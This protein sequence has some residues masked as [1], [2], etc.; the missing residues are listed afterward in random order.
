MCFDQ[1][2]I[3]QITAHLLADFT[4][5]PHQKANEKNENGFQ[6]RYLKYHVLVVFSFSWI[7]SFQWSFI[8]GAIVIALTHWLADGIKSYYKRHNQY[9]KYI[10]FIDQILHLIIILCVSKLYTTFFEVSPIFYFS[11][12]TVKLLIILSFLFCTKPANIMIKEVFR[13]FDIKVIKV[14]ESEELPNAGKLIGII[15]RW[16]VLRFILLNQFE[17]VG[18]LL[19]AK[20]ILRFKEAE[21]LKSEYVLIGT[22]LS[23]AIAIAFGIS[24]SLVN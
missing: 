18:F 24:V 9:V 7:L 16:L 10:F 11:V 2:L 4:F 21:T 6:S 5:Q 15:E 13:V 23:F 12:S 8:V 20:S 14:G 22:M 3:F 19:A 1:L 17:A